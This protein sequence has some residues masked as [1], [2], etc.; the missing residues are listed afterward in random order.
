[1]EQQGIIS[2]DEA[3]NI[4]SP[5]FKT[6]IE[7]DNHKLRKHLKSKPR[8]KILR[9]NFQQF[10]R[11]AASLFVF[12]HNCYVKM[13]DV[14]ITALLECCMA[15]SSVTGYLMP[16]PVVNH[17]FHD[18]LETFFVNNNALLVHFDALLSQNISMQR[19]AEITGYK[20]RLERILNSRVPHS[21]TAYHCDGLPT[22]SSW[23]LMEDEWTTGL[24]YSLP[25]YLPSGTTARLTF[26]QGKVFGNFHQIFSGIACPST[27]Y[28]F[29]GAPDI[30]LNTQKPSQVDGGNDNEEEM[31]VY[32]DAVMDVAGYYSYMDESDTSADE[33]EFVRGTVPVQKSQIPEKV[34][35]VIAALHFLAA[36]RI[37][38]NLV[39]KKRI[40]RSVTVKGSLVDKNNGVIVCQLTMEPSLAT[41]NVRT[42]VSCI[43]QS[44]RLTGSSICHHIQEL[45]NN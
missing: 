34:G 18:G 27:V 28:M 5:S 32:Y 29:H 24:Y 39:N 12:N 26:A 7:E 16:C 23:Q 15:I 38:K 37:L 45:C 43:E 8:S 44:G 4:L 22:S 2:M 35:Q 1:M 17:G 10:E 25:P 31:D 30:I 11:L 41:S 36:S 42:K 9:H 33:L 19:R 6:I 13:S 3:L 20:E 21:H 14:T 40:L